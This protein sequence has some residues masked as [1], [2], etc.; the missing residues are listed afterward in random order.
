[1]A[2]LDLREFSRLLHDAKLTLEKLR[3]ATAETLAETGLPPAARKRILAAL[4]ASD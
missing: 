2:S 4:A 3:G 1:M